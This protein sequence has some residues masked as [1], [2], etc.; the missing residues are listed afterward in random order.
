MV[1]AVPSCRHFTANVKMFPDTSSVSVSTIY[2]PVNNASTGTVHVQHCD[3]T[4][5]TE[6]DFLL[7]RSRSIFTDH[8]QDYY[9]QLNQNEEDLEKETIE[10]SKLLKRTIGKENELRVVNAENRTLEEEL[11]ELENT[12]TELDKKRD[13]LKN[14]LKIL[15]DEDNALRDLLVLENNTNDSSDVE[16]QVERMLKIGG[17][18]LVTNHNNQ[19][20]VEF[21]PFDS[22]RIKLVSVECKSKDIKDQVEKG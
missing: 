6:S 18:I 13:S 20:G 17:R 4:T 8:E 5:E 7:P 1:S 3:T 21:T 16:K 9:Q 10:F 19:E 15:S 11:A 14:E 22:R 12:M 2:V